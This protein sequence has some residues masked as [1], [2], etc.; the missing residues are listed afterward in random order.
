MSPII[1]ILLNLP[2]WSILLLLTFCILIYMILK[3]IS[4]ILRLPKGPTPF[5]FLGNALQIPKNIPLWRTLTSWS[6]KYGPIFTIYLCRTPAIIIS[7]P[8]IAHELLAG[9]SAK[10]SSRPRMVMFGEVYSQMSSVVVQPYGPSWSMRRKLFHQALVCLL[11][12]PFLCGLCNLTN[13]FWVIES[14]SSSHI[15]RPP[16]SRSIQGSMAGSS[17]SRTLA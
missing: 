13:E 14:P 4:T 5:P 12:S 17:G 16:R 3:D 7:D 10:Y 1:H 15:C 8:H 11:P 6:E 2:F 9:R